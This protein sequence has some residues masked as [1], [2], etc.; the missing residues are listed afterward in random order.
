MT[1]PRA[2]KQEAIAR[3]VAAADRRH[4]VEIAAQQE[5]HLSITVEIIRQR[6][7][8]RRELGFDR[9]SREREAALSIVDRDR[10]RELARLEELGL[11]QLGRRKNIL[12]PAGAERRIRHVLAPELRRS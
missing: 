8:Y 2:A 3:V 1:I 9:Q 11:A 10:A 7:I 4:P 5:I 6:R 12:D